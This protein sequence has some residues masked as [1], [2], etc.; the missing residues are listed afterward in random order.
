[1]SN[2]PGSIDAGPRL[3][4]A[5][6]VMIDKLVTMSGRDA[7]SIVISISRL[8]SAGLASGMALPIALASD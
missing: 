7:H 2:V 3:S 8:D 5:L 1:M 4:T 6:W